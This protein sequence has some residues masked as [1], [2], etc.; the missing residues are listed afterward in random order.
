MMAAMTLSSGC[1]LHFHFGEKHIHHR[2]ESVEDVKDA[3]R[4]AQEAF[5]KEMTDGSAAKM[6]DDAG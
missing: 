5:F 1:H 2:V 6:E 3:A 4:D